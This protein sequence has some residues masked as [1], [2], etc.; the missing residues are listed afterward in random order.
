MGLFRDELAVVDLTGD[1]RVAGAA[2]NCLDETAA[3]HVIVALE[4]EVHTEFGEDGRPV[5]AVVDDI[6][7]VHVVG[8]GIQGLVVS[9]EGPHA[10]RLGRGNFIS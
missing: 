1:V 7:V 9:D 5:L 4:D 10:L 3:Q 8:A 6:G 2:A